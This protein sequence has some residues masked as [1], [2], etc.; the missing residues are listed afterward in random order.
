MVFLQMICF[1]KDNNSLL[2]RI[3]NVSSYKFIII[4]SEDLIFS[5]FNSEIQIY[6]NM[7][8]IKEKQN[9]KGV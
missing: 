1:Q 2:F 3:V 7:L 9:I 8:I 4:K 6:H 5:I